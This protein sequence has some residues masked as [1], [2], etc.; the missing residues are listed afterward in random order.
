MV[1]KEMDSEEEPSASNR[2]VL[3][4]LADLRAG[5]PYVSPNVLWDI[6]SCRDQISVAIAP[7]CN[8]HGLQPI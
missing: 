6:W 8:R 2:P 4:G 3:M 5:S 7:D 1:P